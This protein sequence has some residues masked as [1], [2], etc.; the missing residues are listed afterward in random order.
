MAL[1]RIHQQSPQEFA[2]WGRA[3]S[4]VLGQPVPLAY[5]PRLPRMAS[6]TLLSRQDFPGAA[7]QPAVILRFALP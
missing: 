6:L 5:Q 4:D 2:R 1:E 3:L 7:G